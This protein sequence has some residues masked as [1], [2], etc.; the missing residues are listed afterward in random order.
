[1]HSHTHISLL[2]SPEAQ[3][4][5]TLCLNGKDSEVTGRIRNVVDSVRSNLRH[6]LSNP[7]RDALLSQ[8]YRVSEDQYV[9]L[10]QSLG[11]DNESFKAEMEQLL[12]RDIQIVSENNFNTAAGLAS[13]SSGL[14]SLA[15]GLSRLFGIK[16]DAFDT[17]SIARL[18]SGSACRSLYGGFVEWRRGWE[19]QELQRL[20]GLESTAPE[21]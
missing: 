21:Y 17:S 11:G 2:S 19:E 7:K 9:D 8:L 1:M 14:S 6:S 4:K 5:V 3:G 12:R 18:G 10:A 15:F 20:R 16:D 13:S